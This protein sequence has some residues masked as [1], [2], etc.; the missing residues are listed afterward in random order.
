MTLSPTVRLRVPAT[1]ANLGPGFD[2]LGL[3]V[4][5]YLE[6]EAR[7]SDR[8][9]FVY[10]GDGQLPNRPDNLLHKGFAAACRAAGREPF[11][12][13]FEV[14]NPIPL[15]RGLG[16]SS[17]ALVAGAAVADLMLG[18]ALGRNGVFEV[19]VAIEGHPDNVAPA[20]YGGF[21]V[22]ALDINDRY[23]TRAL[24]VPASWRLL[25]AVP[26]FELF[27]ESARRLLPASYSRADAVR[28]ASRAALWTLAVA[29]DEPA[30]LRT[31]S[32]DV[33][34]QPYRA[35]LMAGF[36]K[37]LADA[38][39]AGAYAAYLSGSGPTIGAVASTAT[40]A[41]VRTVLER[42]AGVQGRVHELT[43]AG[44]YQ[45]LPVPSVSALREAL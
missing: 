19:T 6:I 2:A 25:F 24:K 11:P 10:R 43:P 30:L 16:S 7:P 33:L 17:A 8:D 40:S 39:E 13:S 9:S 31:A 44:G 27:T 37:C 1:S 35:P 38:F 14:N 26:E 23:I 3:A 45:S 29:R 32:L 4:G 18:G 22:S 12:V 41:Q 28:T 20:V 34:H 5:L 15:A 42:Y 21:T 36:D